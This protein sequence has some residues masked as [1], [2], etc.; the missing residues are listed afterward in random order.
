MRVKRSM[1]LHN[2]PKAWCGAW[3]LRYA[4]FTG[5]NLGVIVLGTV[6]PGGLAK[7]WRSWEAGR[8]PCSSPAA[9]ACLHVM[10]V[11]PHLLPLITMRIR[12]TW[13]DSGNLCN[14]DFE[15]QSDTRSVAGH[16]KFECWYNWHKMFFL[17]LALKWRSKKLGFEYYWDHI[18]FNPCYRNLVS[19]S[20]R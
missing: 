17:E 11:F 7:V 3:F 6:A 10:G 16:T 15:G 8:K 19:R 2:P 13:E 5:M 14:I 20:K 9:L 18:R 4:L 12:R 1:H